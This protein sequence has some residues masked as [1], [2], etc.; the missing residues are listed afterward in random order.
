MPSTERFTMPVAVHVFLFDADRVL[1]LRRFNTGFED[2][3]FS[4]P[5]GHL[6]GGETVLEATARELAEEI[7]VETQ[8]SD[9]QVVGVMHRK[10]A[11]ERIDFFVRAT[12]WTGA[13]ANREPDKCDLLAWFP[14]DDLPP[15]MVPYVRHAL[16]QHLCGTWFS[17]H[18]WTTLAAEA[19]PCSSPA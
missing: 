5:A 17:E 7:G 19:L 10:S 3:N 15:N 1:L 18:G 2:G 8:P 6:D 4:V 14:L 16:R 9:L 12:A 13:P 11:A